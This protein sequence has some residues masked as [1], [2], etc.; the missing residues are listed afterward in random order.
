[1]AIRKHVLAFAISLM[2]SAEVHAQTQAQQDRLNQ[3]AQYVVTAPMC[4][5]LGMVLAPDSPDRAEA[6]LDAEMAT[7]AI[8]PEKRTTLKNEAVSRQGKMLGIDLETASSGAKTDAQLRNVKTILMGYG[9]T[10][11]AASSDPLFTALIVPPADYDLDKAA[12]DA[13]DTMLEA[14]GLASWQT[15]Q[16][17]AR[18]DLMMV[19]GVCRSRIGAARSDALLRQFGQSDNPRVRNYYLKSFDEGLSDPTLISSLAG[20]NRAIVAIQARIH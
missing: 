6:R 9:R 3:A 2:V 1:M 4:A 8:D 12:T 14:G 13:A 7:W 5:R 18:G 20:C 15:P 16:I 10:C 17:Q 11:L 19:A